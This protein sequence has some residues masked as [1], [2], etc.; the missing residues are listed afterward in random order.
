MI[1]DA[2][3]HKNPGHFWTGAP[4]AVSWQQTRQSFSCFRFSEFEDRLAQWQICNVCRASM[5]S[6]RCPGASKQA[7]LK[8]TTLLWLHAFSSSISCRNLACELHNVCLCSCKVIAHYIAR[9]FAKEIAALG[10]LRMHLAGAW[11]H[12]GIVDESAV[13]A[14]KDKRIQK[15]RAA[16]RSGPAL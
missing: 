16:P 9:W 5:T 15:P 14:E 2:Q 6:I 10:W 12:L 13:R 3:R 11:R 7:A 4:S 1:T 8:P